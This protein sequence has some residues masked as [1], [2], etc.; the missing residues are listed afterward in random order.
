[1]EALI[2]AVRKADAK[3]VKKR[4]G[5]AIGGV[6]PIGHPEPVHMLIDEDL[7]ALE[8]LWAAAGHPHAVFRLTPRQTLAMTGAHAADVALRVAAA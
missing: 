7:L 2:G 4:I 5:Y 6:C 1:M 3:F 8:I